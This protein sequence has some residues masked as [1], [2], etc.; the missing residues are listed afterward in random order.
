MK[1]HPNPLQKLIDKDNLITSPI[2]LTDVH[3]QYLVDLETMPHTSRIAILM[4]LVAELG[5]KGGL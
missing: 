3:Y 1:L 4:N 5:Q 2:K